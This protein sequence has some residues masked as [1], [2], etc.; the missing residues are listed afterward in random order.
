MASLIFHR[1]TRKCSSD[2]PEQCSR[3]PYVVALCERSV[4]SCVCVCVCVCVNWFEVKHIQHPTSLLYISQKLRV[5]GI[6][7]VSEPPVLQALPL[8]LSLRLSVPLSL[9]FLSLSLSLFF[10]PSLS[11]HISVPLSLCFSLS[12]SLPLSLSFSL[13]LFLSISL[14]VYL[15]V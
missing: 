8:S 10:S 15:F 4:G 3:I 2:P 6:R 12:L 5:S 7:H 1:G 13:F 14:S 11:L 9:C